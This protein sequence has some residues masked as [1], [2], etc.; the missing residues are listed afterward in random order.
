ML[1]IYH[2]NY[3]VFECNDPF[4]AGIRDVGEELKL[5][6][7]VRVF[8]GKFHIFG[9]GQN[10]YVFDA[11]Y[12][13][14]DWDDTAGYAYTTGDDESGA[15]IDFTYHSGFHS[16][17]YIVDG[18]AVTDA[19]LC[20][21]FVEQF[22]FET[23]SVIVGGMP[24]TPVVEEG[25]NV[26]RISASKASVIV[27]GYIEGC[28]YCEAA[29]PEIHL[30]HA[31]IVAKGNTPNYC[32]AIY[33]A[34]DSKNIQV[35]SDKGSEDNYI[36]GGVASVKNIK[37]SAK[38]DSVI[39]FIGNVEGS[40]VMFCNGAGSVFVNKDNK[41]VGTEL[42]VGNDD[43]DVSERDTT[44]NFKGDVY[45]KLKARLNSDN[46]NKGF[47]HVTADF[48]G[49]VFTPC[50]ETNQALLETASG[51][52]RITAKIIGETVASGKIYFQEHRGPAVVTSDCATEYSQEDNA[53]L[54]NKFK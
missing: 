53:T 39:N 45:G 38:S 37:I 29:S 16:M 47:A 19:N 1:D 14:M 26:Y 18:P 44:K 46:N 7:I 35:Q 43:S 17:N 20:N 23:G 50:I 4:G 36:I 22:P 5:R 10:A 2:G 48:E 15:N 51:K 49:N 13:Y 32:N 11:K 9:M 42:W 25:T 27:R 3:F 33:Y 30:N 52:T 6:G 24:V 31:M 34:V 21:N 54:V 12:T 41:V 40:T 8:G 28:I